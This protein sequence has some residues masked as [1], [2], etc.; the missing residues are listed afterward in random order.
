MNDFR[1][2]GSAVSYNPAL[3]GVRGVAILIVVLFHARVPGFHAG[4]FGVD[5]FFV[6][7]GFLIT[8]ILIREHEETGT[9]RW[10]RFVLRRIFRLGPALAAMCVGMLVMSIWFWPSAVSPWREV[11]FV[12]FYLSDIT[13]SVL[14]EPM[15]LSHTWSLSVEEHFYLVWP[16][17]ILFCL[18]RGR[19]AFLVVIP[20][21]YVVATAWRIQLL[22]YGFSWREVYFRLDA[23]LGGLMFGALIATLFTCGLLEKVMKYQIWIVVTPSLLMVMY[24]GGWQVDDSLTYGISI[25]EIFAGTL[26]LAALNA[27][28]VLYRA[29]SVP[30]LC[31]LGKVSYGLYLWHYPI[32]RVLRENLGWMETIAFG[33]PVSLLLAVLS[34]VTVERWGLRVRARLIDGKLH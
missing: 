3:D 17:V 10:G 15:A 1:Y 32:F 19:W 23:R 11:L 8:L 14:R 25:V 18:S 5:V 20:V 24:A 13:V 34:Y 28:G 30:A 4:F 29:L 33:L 26:V 2:S 9:I 31:F 27:G 16:L 22:D 21:L 12:M 7:S 6:L